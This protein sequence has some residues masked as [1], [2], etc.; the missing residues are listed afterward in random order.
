MKIIKNPELKDNCVD[1]RIDMNWK[2]MITPGC[3]PLT[4]PIGLDDDLLKDDKKYKSQTP[5]ERPAKGDIAEDIDFDGANDRQ[6]GSPKEL[7]LEFQLLRISMGFQILRSFDDKT[8]DKNPN[9]TSN[10]QK[11]AMILAPYVTAI[12]LKS[13]YPQLSVQHVPSST[14]SDPNQKAQKRIIL[15][16]VEST[17]NPIGQKDSSFYLD[18]EV[19]VFSILPGPIIKLT[20]CTIFEQLLKIVEMEIW[21]QDGHGVI[22][23]FDV[24]MYLFQKLGEPKSLPIR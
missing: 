18:L 10:L 12:S 24:D 8:R 21:D 1:S 16:F 19:V 15:L 22:I 4:T 6:T 23:R 14:Q 13:S 7:F 11:V 9:K 20:I 3:L 5:I 2:S 17:I